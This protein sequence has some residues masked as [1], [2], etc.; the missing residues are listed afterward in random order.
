MA[1]IKVTKIKNL[2]IDPGNGTAFA[3]DTPEMMPKAH[4]NC[5]VVGPRG[6]GKTVATVN[7]VERMGYDRIFIISPSVA[8]NRSVMDRLR[9]DPDDVYPD[10]NASALASI[11]RKI[12][13]ERDDLEEFEA[14]LARWKAFMHKL[15]HSDDTHGMFSDDML[16]FWD[17]REF[18]KPVWKYGMKDGKPRRPM[19][20]LILDDCVGSDLYTRGIRQLNAFTIFHRHLGQ[21]HG[22]EGGAIGCSLY[23]LVQSYKCQGGG[24]SKCI[25]NNT[26]SLIVFRTKSEKE[27]DEISDECSGEISKQDFIKLYNAAMVDKHSFLFIDLH[28]KPHHPSGFRR[29]LDEFLQI[30]ESSETK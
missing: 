8:S 2:A 24:L 14:D 21:L 23:F 10:P 13:G 30:P 3:Y 29:N 17:G 16:D 7:L 27:L 9:I 19:L 26:T 22:P 12:E 11:K 1:D 25:R 6:S 20:A 18:I 4:Q 15:K 28:R 5:L